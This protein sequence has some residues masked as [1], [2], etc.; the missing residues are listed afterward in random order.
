ML[1][2]SDI[3]DKPPMTIDKGKHLSIYKRNAILDFTTSNNLVT[4]EV[5]YLNLATFT[6][7]IIFESVSGDKTPKMPK[8]QKEV[9]VVDKSKYLVFY[10]KKSHP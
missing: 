4:L 2:V 7:I 8:T 5:I 9:K 1:F 3:S 6:P 10:K